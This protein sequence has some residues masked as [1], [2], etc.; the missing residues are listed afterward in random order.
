MAAKCKRVDLDFN[1]KME[2]LK[3]VDGGVKRK[4]IVGKFDVD[5]STLS[6]LVKNRNKLE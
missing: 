6:K 1:S 4:Y 2:I 3:Q 5:V